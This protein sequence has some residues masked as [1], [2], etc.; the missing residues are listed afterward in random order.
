MS[1]RT[2]ESYWSAKKKISKET[3]TRLAA[4]RKNSVLRENGFRADLGDFEEDLARERI[5]WNWAK[6]MIYYY[7]LQVSEHTKGKILMGIVTSRLFLPFSLSLLLTPSVSGWDRIWRWGH[8]WIGHREGKWGHMGGPSSH[9]TDVLI[10]RED[11][12]T[13]THSREG[14]VKTK[15]RTA[16][17][18]PTREASEETEPATSWPWT[19]ASRTVRK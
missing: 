13:D 7:L 2:Q 15:V 3:P 16:I 5:C 6:F 4:G 14:H 19:L 9:V 17:H 18:K 11:W 10:R 1:Q 12:S 8:L